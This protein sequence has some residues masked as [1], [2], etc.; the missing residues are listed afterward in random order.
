RVVRRA[1]EAH[2][3]VWVLGRAGL[4]RLVHLVELREPTGD[5]GAQLVRLGRQP[6]K[7]VA[8]AE[9]EVLVA[10]ADDPGPLEAF[11]GERQ[12]AERGGKLDEPLPAVLLAGLRQS[13]EPREDALVLEEHGRDEPRARPIRL[14]G[15]ALR[16][17]VH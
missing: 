11:G 10:A 15:E 13:R 12:A 5:R 3:P 4:V 6:Q 2:A 9:L 7:A 16:E 1:G 17:R 8:L 14:R